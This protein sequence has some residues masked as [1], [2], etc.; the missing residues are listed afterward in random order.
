M[1]YDPS[2]LNFSSAAQENHSCLFLV[3]EA[4]GHEENERGC[5]GFEE[6]LGIS[7][8]IQEGVTADDKE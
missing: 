5:L 1:Y 4:T 2:L 8:S 6:Y 3:L 7:T